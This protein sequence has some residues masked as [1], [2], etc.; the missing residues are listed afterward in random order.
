MSSQFRYALLLIV[1]LWQSL[2]MGGP[3]AVA[4]FAAD[5]DHIKVHCDAHHHHHHADQTLHMDS[6][7]DAKPTHQHAD[8]GSNAIGLLQSEGPTLSALSPAMPV[9]RVLTAWLSAPLDGPLR[10][11]K[12][13]A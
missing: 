11:P 7:D 2:V 10:P 12:Q 1:L 9:D 13:L 8:L 4:Q 6:A 5:L 3:L